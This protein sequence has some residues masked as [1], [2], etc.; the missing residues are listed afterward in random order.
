M[1][2]LTPPSCQ[3][4]HAVQI[5]QRAPLLLLLMSA[6]ET[7]D[8]QIKQ[9]R[10]TCV[11]HSNQNTLNEHNPFT[12]VDTLWSTQYFLS[13]SYLGT[14]P[15]VFA[16]ARPEKKKKGGSPWQRFVQFCYSCDVCGDTFDPLVNS[17][18]KELSRVHTQPD[19]HAC[20]NV[21]Y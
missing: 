17:L 20:P 21:W 18:M 10:H 6:A 4:Y 11:P 12:S 13:F 1:E 7:T 16:L 3:F 5:P 9:E 14:H 15:P 19:S 2:L 8:S